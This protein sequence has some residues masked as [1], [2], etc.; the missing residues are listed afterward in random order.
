DL[1]F[2]MAAEANF[3][4][5]QSITVGFPA[6]SSTASQTF[7]AATP[8]VNYWSDWE[9]KTMSFTASATSVDLQFSAATAEDVGLDSVSVTAGASVPD[10]GSTV[11][12][13]GMAVT[14]LGGVSGFSG[15]FR[16]LL[17]GPA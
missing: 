8:L 6:G 16:R 5:A 14:L 17:A 13:L 12:L 1:V 10:A 2:K 11:G 4:G 3:S 9:T 15:R 7:T